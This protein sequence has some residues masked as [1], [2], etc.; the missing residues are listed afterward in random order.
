MLAFLLD[1]FFLLALGC[2]VLSRLSDWLAIR[3][4]RI[5]STLAQDGVSLSAEIMR[6]QKARYTYGFRD[7]YRS[8]CLTYQFRDQRGRVFSRKQWIS[9]ESYS[10]L[11]RVSYIPPL[12]WFF[13]SDRTKYLKQ[14]YVSVVYLPTRPRISRLA[15]PDADDMRLRDL[16]SAVR[17]FHLVALFVFV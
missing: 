12:E 16:S 1:P 2:L 4:R 6:L 17:V 11:T 14:S 10:R 5:L 9:Q 3:E 8:Y 7:Y 15:G 13:R